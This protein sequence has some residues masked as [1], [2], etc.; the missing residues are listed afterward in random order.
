M[1]VAQN[2]AIFALLNKTG[3]MAQ[4]ENLVL[5]FSG[6]RTATTKDLYNDEINDLIRYLKTQDKDEAGAE[7][8]RRKIIAMA[9]RLGWEHENGKVDM[10][11]LDAWCVNKGYL[12]KKLNQYLYNELPKLVWQFK[13]T[14]GFY[15]KKT[16]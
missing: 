7:K 13:E 3:L 12:K 9:H 16:A 8:M 10:Q 15:I 1:N 11:R 6:G 14:Y 4:K 2:K 5:G